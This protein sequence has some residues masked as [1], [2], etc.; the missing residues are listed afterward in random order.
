[1][2]CFCHSLFCI[3]KNVCSSKLH[4]YCITGEEHVSILHNRYLS[5]RSAASM[6]RFGLAPVH[7][8]VYQIC[9]YVSWQRLA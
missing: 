4:I 6:S 1:M 3:E 8:Y 7:I 5:Y 9:W 2:E